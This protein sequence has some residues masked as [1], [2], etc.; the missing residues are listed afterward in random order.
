ME[1]L[2]A[3]LTFFKKKISKPSNLDPC[4]EESEQQTYIEAIKEEL[5]QAVRTL[6]LLVQE[7]IRKDPITIKLPEKKNQGWNKVHYEILMTPHL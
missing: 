4:Q 7:K 5:L 1:D 2:E 3:F 6:P